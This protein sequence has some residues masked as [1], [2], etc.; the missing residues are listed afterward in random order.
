MRSK[1]VRLEEIADVQ[2]GGRAE[3]FSG[4]SVDVDFVTNFCVSVCDEDAEEKQI[5]LLEKFSVMSIDCKG[6]VEVDA[7]NAETKK[8]KNPK[9]HV[10]KSNETRKEKKI[11]TNIKT[12]K[13]KKI[14][15]NIETQKETRSEKNTENGAETRKGTK[16]ERKKNHANERQNAVEAEDGPQQSAAENGRQRN[17]VENGNLRAANGQLRF[18]REDGQGCADRTGCLG[19]AAED[20][21]LRSDTESVSLRSTD[22]DVGIREKRVEEGIGWKKEEVDAMEE[23]NVESDGQLQEVFGNI[24]GFPTRRRPAESKRNMDLTS[25]D[26]EIAKWFTQDE[27]KQIQIGEQLT[28]TEKLQGMR[29]LYIWRD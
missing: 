7:P 18:A 20:V 1:V 11:K 9:K 27:G 19:S 15:T 2:Y 12:R 21:A 26:E 13:E 10:G 17:A 28:E 22:G 3:K 4:L 29:L 14:E 23:G 16:P 8:E 5:G 25:S 6:D 24:L